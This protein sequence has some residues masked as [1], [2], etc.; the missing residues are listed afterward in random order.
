MERIEALRK[1]AATPGAPADWRSWA[2]SAL[3][4][5]RQLHLGSAGVAYAPFYDDVLQFARSR[6]APSDLIA[7][8]TFLRAGREWD[9]ALALSLADSLENSVRAGQPWIAPDALRDVTVTAHLLAGDLARARE[10]LDALTPLGDTTSA[11]Y[12][13]RTRI[14]RAAAGGADHAVPPRGDK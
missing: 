12:R 10:G 7:S 1:D 14:L 6:Q 5:E 3:I 4:L 11:G 13:F 9:F 2:E 8:L